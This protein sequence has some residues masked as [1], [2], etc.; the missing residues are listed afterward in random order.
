M[1]PRELAGAFV[2]VL[3]LLNVPVHA[4]TKSADFNGDLKVDL[5]AYH[6]GGM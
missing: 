2:L 1:M 3:L 6:C 5:S 4:Q